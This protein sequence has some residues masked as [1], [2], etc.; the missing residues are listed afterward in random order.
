MQFIS[1][2]TLS[3]LNTSTKVINTN[4]K[5]LNFKNTD[6]AS[7]CLNRLFRIRG[8]NITVHELRHTYVT[9]LISD[10][11]PFKTGAQFL[12]HTIEQ[13]MKTYSHENNDMLKKATISSIN[14]IL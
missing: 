7:I 9:M 12:G 1:P 2:K 3:L 11:V 10:G 13:T 6:S 8:Y 5:V 4:N 14:N